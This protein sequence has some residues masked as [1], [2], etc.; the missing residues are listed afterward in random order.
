MTWNDFF[1]AI[2]DLAT[3]KSI[4][5][6]SKF[7]TNA[8]FGAPVAHWENGWRIR[9]A[10]IPEFSSNYSGEPTWT[11]FADPTVGR[12]IQ[13]PLKHVKTIICA[14][15]LQTWE[16]IK[17][18]F[19]KLVSNSDNPVWWEWWEPFFSL[20]L[21]SVFVNFIWKYPN[22]PISQD[23]YLTSIIGKNWLKFI[24]VLHQTR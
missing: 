2:G 23:I 19:S 24:I 16:G 10:T 17:S 1:Y 4:G 9:S 13:L 21:S 15:H 7:K 3:T 11:G 12:E 14:I 20:W 22:F 5:G 8:L 6:Y 18:F